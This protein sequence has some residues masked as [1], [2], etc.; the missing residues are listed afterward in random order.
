MSLESLPDDPAVL[1]ATI[2]QLL[3]AVSQNEQLIARLQQQLEQLLRNRFGKKSEQLLPNQLLIG[4]LL[5]PADPPAAAPEP[6]ADAEAADERGARGRGRRPLPPELPRRRVEHDLPDGEKTCPN[7]K[8]D[9]KRIGE[10]IREQLEYVPAS[11]L[12]LQHVRFKYACPCCQEHVMRAPAP[13]TPIDRGLPGPGLLA[14]VAAS[15]HADHLPL[16][17]LEGILAR[18]GVEISRQTMC[19]WLAAAAGLLEPVVGR[20]R[21]L[22]LQSLVC[23][24]DDT[25]VPV[26]DPDRPGQTKTGRLWTYLGDADHPYI[27]FDYTPTRER[28]GPE[29]FLKDFK[30]FLQADACPVYDALFDKAGGPTEVGCWAHARRGFFEAKSSDPARSAYALAVVGQLYGVERDTREQAEAF[31]S[32][33]SGP[34]LSQKTAEHASHRLSQT[35]SESVSP[36]VCNGD[37]Q[38]VCDPDSQLGSAPAALHRAALEQARLELRR[39]RSLP[40]LSAF[41]EWLEAESCKVLPKSPMGQAIAY[42][43]SNWAALV[44]YTEAGFLDID[45]NASE[46]A[47]KLVVLG[48]KNWLFAG[49]DAGGRT[50]ATWFSLTATCKRLRLDPFAYLRA[51]LDLVSVHPASRLDD[52]L[53]DRWAAG[54][55]AAPPAG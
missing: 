7:C 34:R 30:G 29:K 28:A 46:R 6:P 22:V 8:V 19:G 9:L 51:V 49:S 11:L 18:H 26:Q 48:R 3:A 31:A 39:E 23:Q 50:A 32:A 1:K 20:M 2:A 13:P 24:T 54:P 41:K 52:L 17:R 37:S 15:K 36:L 5:Q 47:I 21:E 40:L 45:N 10:E 53:P 16:Y 55:F 27:V 14:H 38:L 12:V 33:R 35:V 44:R 43:L 4:D 42:A 25:T